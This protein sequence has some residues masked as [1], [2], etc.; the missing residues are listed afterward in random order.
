MK[1]IPYCHNKK[2]IQTEE[3]NEYSNKNGYY[4]NVHCE[5]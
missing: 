1:I 5:I 2:K 4:G 3:K